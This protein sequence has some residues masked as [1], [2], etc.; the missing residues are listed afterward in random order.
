MHSVEPLC[1]NPT[2]TSRSYVLLRL[3]VSNE[4]SIV[5]GNRRRSHSLE[6]N[7]VSFSDG[8]RRGMARPSRLKTV[9]LFVLTLST[10]LARISVKSN[11]RSC[12]NVRYTCSSFTS[13]FR[14]IIR[15]GMFWFQV[16]TAGL[17][18]RASTSPK[19]PYDPKFYLALTFKLIYFRNL[20]TLSLT[21]RVKRNKR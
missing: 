12:R 14:K 3:H 17:G 19:I 2:P 16:R 10:S 13:D 20:L 11:T 18:K 8:A 21:S 1:P 4:G 15:S 7:I 9:R 6:S 5:L